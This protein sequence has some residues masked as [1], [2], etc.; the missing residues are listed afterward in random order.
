MPRMRLLTW[1]ALIGLIL[2]LAPLL[3]WNA[4]TRLWSHYGMQRMMP[5]TAW[6]VE[7][8]RR[9]PD[10]RA[11]RLWLTGP[12]IESLS[13]ADQGKDYRE[14]Y[15]PLASC[16]L[17]AASRLGLAHGFVWVSAWTLALFMGVCL[18]CALLAWRLTRSAA[19]ALFAA[20]LC[21]D[22][23]DI[24]VSTPSYWLA[25]LPVQQDLLMLLFLLGTLAAYDCWKETAERRFL[26]LGRACLLLGC[27][28]KEYDY[29]L[30]LMIPLVLLNTQSRAEAV[31]KAGLTERRRESLLALGMAVGFLILRQIVL[32][33]PFRPHYR[34][35]SWKTHPFFNLAG[36]F[37]SYIC[38][39]IYWL[40]L[41][42]L[43]LFLLAGGLIQAQA[44]GWMWAFRPRLWLAVAACAAVGLTADVL[45]NRSA[46]TDWVSEKVWFFADTK[47]RGDHILALACM[48]GYLYVYYLIVKRRAQER[49]VTVFG[50]VALA[51]LPVVGLDGYHYWLGGAVLRAAFWPLLLQAAWADAWPFLSRKRP[52]QE[53]SRP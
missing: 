20:V 30:A 13:V 7:G 33:H 4:D 16:D 10:P 53:Y 43:G 3:N 9:T 2:A 42:A 45:W 24:D 18:L 14:F 21:A 50:L 48:V 29:I 47:E 17:W 51:Y 8:A 38:G 5:D 15:R 6:I 49:M 37:Y 22:I 31:P 44:R 40:P 52:S 36:P 27:L 35:W 39:H 11:R 28:T 26:W 32:P 19:C 41:L 12:W 1:A 34:W 25:W 46:L 23:R